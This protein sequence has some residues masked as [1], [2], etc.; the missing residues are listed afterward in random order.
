MALHGRRARRGGRRRD[1]GEVT[2]DAAVEAA[3][4][5]YAAALAPAGEDALSDAGALKAHR[6]AMD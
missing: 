3:W 2:R 4:R 6:G 5:D 1:G